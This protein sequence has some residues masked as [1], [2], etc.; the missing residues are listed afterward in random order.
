VLRLIPLFLIAAAAA[1]AQPFLIRSQVGQTVATIAN[2]GTV[3]LN[4]DAIGVPASAT[5]TITYRGTGSVNV[6]TIEY[7]GSLDFSL[8]GLPDALPLVLLPNQSITLGVQFRPS[9]SARL[10]GRINI[11]YAEGRTA[12]TLTV[13]LAG[14]A[15]EFAFSYVPPGGN[16]TPVT[17]GGAISFPATPVDT[18]ANAAVV[19][20]NRGSGPGV[21]NAISSTGAAFQLAGLPL[22]MTTVEAGRDLRFTVAFT[23]KQLEPST[24]TLSVELIDRRVN[25]NLAGSGTGPVYTYEALQES[26]AVVLEPNQTLPMPDALIGD[27]SSVTLRV[28]NAGNADGRIEQIAIQGAGFTLTDVPFL[29][30]TLTPGGS[31][32]FTLTFTPTQAGRVNGRLRVGNHTFEVTG[33]GLGATLTYAYAIGSVTTTVTNNGSVIFTPVSV[34]TTAASRFQITNTGT[35]AASVSS[36]SI[37]GTGTVF[38]LSDLPGLPANIPP[39]GTVSFTI[40]FA[41][42]ALGAATGTLRIDNQSFT[43]SGTG[44][45]PAALPEYRFQTS[46]STQEPLQQ[47]AVSLT[48]AQAYPL[49]LNGTLTLAFNSDVFANDPAV[50]FATGGRTV[51]FII[52]ANRTQAVFPDNTTQIRLQ[53]GTVAGTISLTPSFATEGGINMT[54]TN[55]PALSITIPQAAPRLLSVVLSARTGTGFTLLVTGFAT[56][57]SITQMEFQFTPVSGETVQTTRLPMNVESSFLAWYQSAQSQQF[58]SL[59]T[60]TIPFTLAGDVKNVSTVVDT[61]QSVA[62]TLTNRQGTSASASVSLK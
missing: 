41:P 54:P 47:P 43:L 33:N 23:P 48:L 20:T 26:G 60:A 30:L 40:T 9:S 61:I 50:Q 45:T 19:V 52:P 2:D 1:V 12:G 18:T 42:N 59:F 21:V 25:L 32:A 56:G 55:P 46:G 35:A 53:T 44:N 34:G 22:P 8:T 16:A 28:R 62:V 4:A 36:I 17:P 10:S 15:P 29:P 39:N 24:G 38:T 37:A 13:N 5:I 3:G 49:Q 31:A 57:R 7:S 27:K 51:N 14:T 6:N 58:G 11:A